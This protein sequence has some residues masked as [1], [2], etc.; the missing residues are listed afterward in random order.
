MGRRLGW[1]VRVASPGP[2]GQPLSKGNAGSIR[3]LSI[4]AP[5]SPEMS[6]CR[7]CP[8]LGKEEDSRHAPPSN[9]RYYEANT[10]P[11]K[12][13]DYRRDNDAARQKHKGLKRAGTAD[14]FHDCP[15]DSF[16]HRRVITHQPTPGD[17]AQGS[18][19][20]INTRS[21]S[22]SSMDGP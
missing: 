20:G 18:S 9:E 21:M 2:R 5:F 17:G 16:A 13:H 15:L 4:D 3:V 12:D 14:G 8:S 10:S 11:A 6:L 19:K 7:A 22:Q 1:S